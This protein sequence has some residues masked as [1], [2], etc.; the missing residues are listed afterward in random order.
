MTYDQWLEGQTT[1]TDQ[2]AVVHHV[3]DDRR[4][5]PRSRRCRCGAAFYGTDTEQ[6]LDLSGHCWVANGQ[7]VD[8]AGFYTVQA[9]IVD[10]LKN[11]PVR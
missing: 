3:E 11:A 8:Q 9:G 4:S 2:T 1:T 5:L 6:R 10:A 7:Q